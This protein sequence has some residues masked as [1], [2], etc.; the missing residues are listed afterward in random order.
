MSDRPDSNTSRPPRRLRANRQGQEAALLTVL[1]VVSVLASGGF[2]WGL[3][4]LA[5][6]LSR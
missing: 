1:S 2:V 6:R 5:D 3:F 4:F